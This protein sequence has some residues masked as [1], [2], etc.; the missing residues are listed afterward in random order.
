[1]Q[2]SSTL[3]FLDGMRGLMAI[4]VFVCHTN[5]AVA[6]GLNIPE[7]SIAVLDGVSL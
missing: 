5:L 7:G 6:G 3:P 4:W 1:M 2:S